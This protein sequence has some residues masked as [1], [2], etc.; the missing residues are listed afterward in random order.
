M[1]AGSG[2]RLLSQHR[3]SLGE[4]LIGR[5]VITGRSHG[6]YRWLKWFIVSTRLVGCLYLNKRNFPTLW[7]PHSFI[8]LV[9]NF[10]ITHSDRSDILLSLSSV[11]RRATPT[12]ILNNITI[13]EGTPKQSV[14][15]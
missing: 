5:Q 7:T 15:G 12:L 4:S 8:H 11:H 1:I 14:V 13:W 6:E 10:Y 2:D 9:Y 3:V